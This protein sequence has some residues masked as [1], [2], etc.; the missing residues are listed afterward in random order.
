[1]IGIATSLFTAVFITRMLIDSAVNK[2]ANLTFQYSIF[3]KIGS[4]ILILNS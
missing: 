1:M 2:N 3:L 4:K